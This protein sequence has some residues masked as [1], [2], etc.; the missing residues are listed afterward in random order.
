[1]LFIE[2]GTCKPAR[3]LAYEDYFLNGKNLK[4]DIFML[5]RNEPAIVVGR[6]QN[7]LEEINTSFVEKHQIQVLR[8]ISGG[9]AVY[10]DP[11]NLCFSFILH[12]IAPEI[13]DKS[14]Y[15]RPLVDALAILGVRAEVTRRNDLTVDGKKFSGN[16]MALHKNRLLFHGTLLFDSDLE[17][18]HE[19]LKSSSV[20][21]DSKA[22][23][24]MRSQV[25]NLKGYLPQ[26]MDIILFKQRLEQ[27]LFTD[28]NSSYFKPDKEDLDAINEL[29]KKK[30]ETWEWN[31]GHN[32]KST[33]RRSWN[34]PE[35][36]LEI[37][38][39]LDKGYI[40][41]CQLKSDFETPTGHDEIE[42]LLKNIRYTS[43]DIRM[44][45]NR[46][47]IPDQL[48]SISRDNLIKMIIG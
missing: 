36:T 16:A 23:R 44:A 21:V 33:F 32:P 27:L 25:T 37:T 24:S 19:A 46:S 11:G 31:F 22:V 45:L 28:N 30:Y 26:S 20:I 2:T 42:N 9:G 4:E 12:D 29:V 13:V 34:S 47:D 5:W 15:I 40:K 10:H 8:R 6:F 17:I 3:N 7:T 38:I 18:L 48:G 43:A 41:S 1:M 35:G 39:Q 14:K